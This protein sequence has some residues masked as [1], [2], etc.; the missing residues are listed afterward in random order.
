MGLVTTHA[1]VWMDLVASTVRSMWM[2][3]FLV[4]AIMVPPVTSMSTLTHA[5]APLVSLVSTVRPTMK[6]ALRVAV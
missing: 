1:F 6:T 2:N 4:H 5:H 3:V